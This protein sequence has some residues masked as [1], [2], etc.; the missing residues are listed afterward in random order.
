M[1]PEIQE[2]KNFRNA[3]YEIL[4]KSKDAIMN[5]LDALTS[6]GHKCKSVVELST[7]KWFE[8]KYSSVTKAISKLSKVNWKEIMELI[9]HTVTK[10]L[11]KTHT[12]MIDATPNKRQFAKKLADRYITYSPNPYPGNKPI[13]AGNQYSLLGVMAPTNEPDKSERLVPISSARVSSDDKGNEL[14]MLQIK[15]AIVSFGLNTTLCKSVGDTLYS[16]NKCR[17]IATE[18]PN[19]VHISRLSISRTVYLQPSANEDNKTSGRPKEYG[20]TMS[21]KDTKTHVPCDNEEQMTLL[22]GR[23][24]QQY[25]ITIKRWNNVLLRGTKTF[26]SSSH[27]IDIIQIT[28]C[29]K[30]NKLLYKNPL[31]ISILGSRRSEVSSKEAYLDYKSRF[32]QE[33]MFRFLKQNLL[34]N[35]YKTVNIDYEEM[36]WKLVTVA[37]A[38][39]YLAKNIA[40]KVIQP[41]EKYLPE[42]K[43]DDEGQDKYSCNPSQTQ[44]G[45]SHLLT[46]IGT[47]AK[48][49]ISRGKS[50][51]RKIGETQIKR[52]SHEIIFKNKN[53][54]NVISWDSEKMT[55][56]SDPLKTQRLITGI[57]T[58]IENLNLKLTFLEKT[59]IDTG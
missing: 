12:F 29:D 50:S 27:P 47:P 39:L 38:Q 33:H 22:L 52:K 4:L 19:L 15:E 57:K 2:L 40:T 14:G 56:I 16:S 13:C 48:P 23:K 1:H 6:S 11:E 54:K 20:A 34:M 30:K 18:C 3:F 55:K 31:W 28:V 37:Y 45:F 49:C 35:C 36:W 44:R 51:G 9:F 17:K 10:G 46:Q 53:K 43:N 59:L 24:K 41:W 32:G 7:S 8:R 25:V 42:N 58:T 21:L 26:K 5:L